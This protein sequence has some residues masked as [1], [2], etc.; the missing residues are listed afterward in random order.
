MKIKTSDLEGAALDWAVAQ[1]ELVAHDTETNILMVTVGDDNDW[2]Y[3]PS[4]NWSQGGPI[5]ESA[6]ITI[7]R[8]NDDYEKDC[9]GFTSLKR[10]PVWFAEC[11]QCVG[12]SPHTSYEGEHM[13]PTFMVGEGDGYYGPAPLIAAMRAFV[14]SQLGEEVEVPDEI[15]PKENT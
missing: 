3:Q 12:H 2:K 11:D 7:I 1:L 13:E 4:S 14:A 15:T 9:Q 10:V 6:N 8:A 5:I